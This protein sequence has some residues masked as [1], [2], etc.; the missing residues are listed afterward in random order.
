MADNN[1]TG[2]Q[3]KRRKSA[4]SV[5]P[6]RR[7]FGD[8]KAKRKVSQRK[9]QKKDRNHNSAGGKEE[10]DGFWRK[11]DNNDTNETANAN[12][13]EYA[14]S[15]K[16]KNGGK[17]EKSSGKKKT[18]DGYRKPFLARFYDKLKPGEYTK[19]QDFRH[20]LVIFSVI[21][22]LCG[23]GGTAF[24]I[25]SN[26]EAY[27]VSAELVIPSAAYTTGQESNVVD[28]LESNGFTNIYE[29]EDGNF[30]AFGTPTRV[31]NYKNAYYQRTMKTVEEDLSNDYSSFGVALVSINSDWSTLTID[32][33][34]DE[35][36]ASTITYIFQSTDLN[37]LVRVFAVWRQINSGGEKMEL[38]IRAADGTILIDEEINSADEIVSRM[39]AEET[40]ETDDETETETDSDIDGDSDS[41]ATTAD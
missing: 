37:N 30:H 7:R 40:E 39:Q 31:Q 9:P 13:L 28:T 29:D 1:K 11:K 32:T 3:Y 8:L 15:G 19:K 10:H 12:E 41:D 22:V 18:D 36:E 23:V 17:A 24:Y 27:K 2:S 16:A 14:S 4:S 38:V 21:L 35:M 26:N 34:Y 5:K 6:S 33:I 25:W 20:V